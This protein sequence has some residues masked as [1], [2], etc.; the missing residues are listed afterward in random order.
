MSNDRELEAALREGGE[1]V[2]EGR[3][4]IDSARA[5]Q[6]LRDFRFADPSHWVL[7]VLRAA[8]GSWAKQVTVTTDADDV[9][10]EF[11]GK[12]LP[13]ALMKDLLERALEPGETHDEQRARLLA[14]GAA[15]AL[16]TGAVFVTIDSGSSSLQ[17]TATQVNLTTHK[18][19][20]SG[21]RFHLRK[22]FGWRV[23][24][25]FFR[26]APEA[27]AVA[28]R[29]RR[30]PA[31]L[32]LNGERL[33]QTDA[34]GAPLFLGVGEAA[35]DPRLREGSL[36]RVLSGEGWRLEVLLPKAQPLART[37]LE[38]DVS[39]VTVASRDLELPGVQVLAWLRADGLRRNASG[40]DVVDDDP[41]LR[42][43]T[44]ELH[45]LSRELLAEH[46]AALAES[47]FWRRDFVHRLV[48]GELDGKTRT[49]L[50]AVPL[51]PGPAGE[52]FTLAAF[53]E[54]MRKEG[55]ISVATQAWTKGT[56][57]EP[58]VLL[59]AEPGLEALLPRGKRVDVKHHMARRERIAE[60]R[61]R[62]EA[63]PTEPAHLHGTH[64]ELRTPI[65]AAQTAGEVG[66]STNVAGAFVRVLHQGRLLEASELMSLAPLRLRAVVDLL[67]PL[68]DSFF[69]D[70]GPK[71]VLGLVHKHVE[72]AVTRAVVA[73]LPS[74]EALPHALDLLTWLVTQQG[75]AK[76]DLPASV[77]PA[78][79]KAL[80]EAPLFPCLGRPA[81]SLAELSHET[82]WQYV[83]AMHAH[84]LLDE[85]RVLV[86]DEQRLA[87][88][89]KIAPK[90]L[91][92]VKDRLGAEREVRRR[93]AGPPEAPLVADI[94]VRVPV[95]G[96]GLQG[97]VGVP[98]R[99]STSL[100]LT[101][102]RKG[103]RLETTQLTAR[104]GHAVAS[105]E[106][107]A[108][109]PNP[110]W[111]AAVRDQAWQRVL[112]AVQ[113][114]ERRL[115]VELVK[116]SRASWPA[117]A[118]VYLAAF[119]E[120]ELRGFAFEQLDDVT[121]A[122]VDAPLFDAGL[123]RVSLRQLKERGV[124]W[125]MPLDAGRPT[126]P[127][128]LLVLFEAPSTLALLGQVV[129]WQAE[130]ALPELQRREARRR[131]RELPET[132]FEVTPGLEDTLAV[133]RPHFRARF[134]LRA[135][136]APEA[137]VQ[138]VLE[139][140]NYTHVTV[141]SAFPL[142]VVL[143]LPG[144]EPQTRRELTDAQLAE[145]KQV[146]AELELAVV[147][148]ARPSDRAALLALGRN[149]DGRLP[150]EH[151]EAL[152]RRPLFPCTDGV[153][154]SLYAVAMAEPR[155]VKSPQEVTLPDGLPIIVA[156]T[157]ALGVALQ[158]WPGA[159]QV[160]EVLAEQRAALR[161][162]EGLTRAE[163]ITAQI[164]SPWRQPI[165]QD[166]V[167]GEVA[168]ARENAGRLEVYLDRRP[169]CVVEG[170]LE[171]PFAAAID[172]KVTPTPAHD[173]VVPDGRWQQV[174]TAVREAT[175]RLAA[176]LDVSQIPE[177]WHAVLTRLAFQQAS[178]EAWQWK[179]K[180]KKKKSKKKG[181]GGPR[182]PTGGALLTAP[183]LRANDATTLSVEQLVA[184]QQNGAK[185]TVVRR[186][187]SFLESGRRAWWPRADE[188][189]W[190]K[191]LGLVLDDCSDELTL[192]DAIRARPRYDR[193]DAPIESAWREPVR[194]P[195]I[196][197]EVALAGAPGGAL[198]IEV[199]RERMLLERY[200]TP[201]HVGGVARVECAAL[202]PAADWASAKRDAQF[203]ALVTATEAALE[204][205]VHRRLSH[206]D[207]Q[208]PTWGRAALRWR[209]GHTGLLS[210]DFPE[211]PLFRSLRGDRVTVGTVLAL[212]ARLRRVPVAVPRDGLDDAEGVL[213]DSLETR[214]SLSVL[215]L[216]FED[217][218]SE[219]VRSADLKK[220]LTARRLSSLAWKGEALLRVSVAQGPLQ[221]ELALSSTPGRVMLARDGIGVAP[222][223]EQWPGVVGVLGVEGLQVNDDWTKASPTRAQVSLVR[224]QVERLYVAL[225]QAAGGW[226]RPA[227]E[228][229]A[230][231][232][233]Q[234]LASEGVALADLDRSSGAVK[235][236]ADAPLFVTVEG[237]K[238]NLRAIAAEIGARG[239][240][241]VFEH[242]PG[243]VTSCVLATSS[244][245]APWLPAL[246]S[247]FGKK[248][249][250]RVSDEAA[251][252]Q[253]VREA[254][255]PEGTALLD[256]LRTLRK[257]VRLLRAGALGH[258]TPDDL[259]DVRLSRDGGDAPLRYD[260]RRKL[261]LLDPQ[262]P[263]VQ[264]ALE[265]A[266]ARPERIWVLVAACFGLVNRALQHVTDHDEAQLLIALAAHLG[267]NPALLE[268]DS[269][270]H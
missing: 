112:A 170:A 189:R 19:A 51:V 169:L 67:R 2:G 57:P 227:R 45:K 52:F 130:S 265:Q 117:G 231:W 244:F 156:D 229:A 68:G 46:A 158:R 263:Q 242:G 97:E 55:R 225:A 11:D 104:Y 192:A 197:G 102:L 165:A 178:A 42:E 233:L 203:K 3:I 71:K 43:A 240:V 30:L 32:V 142:E 153:T 177:G 145:V 202:T 75:W 118:E 81:T 86:L 191:D 136:V 120:K 93:I 84:G 26:G 168:L 100:A 116:W 36:H 94:V 87:L 33:G 38:L 172:A 184:E 219:L 114:A 90:R 236:L 163:R 10:V 58:T 237:E 15:G 50:Q 217:V 161:R 8:V 200:S 59:L 53:V 254:D 207:L 262:H 85:S 247:L 216:D 269:G 4:R 137:R 150:L 76:D 246:E 28:T 126:I 234:F 18:R 146:V 132:R 224:A 194:G 266:R 34:K 106:C 167:E 155:Y 56:Y 222:L 49:V 44:R 148:A 20:R 253:T 54:D 27:R 255:P 179:G 154:R 212:A 41:L 110:R 239:K 259:E 107:A 5:L 268:P 101:V 264:Q 92:D 160:D 23:V 190:A 82:R 261:V 25:G 149:L 162:R 267:A 251:W 16:G 270:N 89:R 176:A 182:A 220:A 134:G 257:E 65:D 211:L 174:L 66:L 248:S 108:L 205:L 99:P 12:A 124:F 258:L 123:V 13:D 78:H 88:L 238:V 181:G 121:R 24:T 166:G 40:S 215:K 109:A 199:L 185:V 187:G 111:T 201:H 103:V 98:A 175:A 21:T 37:T 250:W 77:Q 196:E 151:A 127:D 171:G 91:E 213:A 188:E 180:A 228:Q 128:D 159:K 105:V 195:G 73:S 157:L 210:A 113:A 9:I 183:L 1:K 22:G 173:G 79:R 214:E 122:V 138:L 48:E 83:T 115:A 64:W 221:G 47:R 7:E 31:K 198:T 218:S 230:S 208:F 17:L 249:V 164:D 139:G 241:A 61:A 193:L 141:P 143:D 63:N 133:D 60:N 119:L 186:G 204:R 72:L 14:L 223:D 209:F 256:G 96:E 245:Q 62:V 152:R 35:P 226:A 74:A 29:A 260:A 129:G 147:S 95:E 232:A 6:R 252:E 69:E 140:R 135:G 131:L 80:R 39:G 235:A 243:R 144:L 125:S 206:R 70:D